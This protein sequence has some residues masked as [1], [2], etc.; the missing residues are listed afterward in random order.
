MG[1]RYRIRID[2]LDTTKVVSG[3]ATAVC[4]CF[5]S[6]CTS[7]PTP[8]KKKTT[9]SSTALSSEN[10]Q[11]SFETSVDTLAYMSC[12]DVGDSNYPNYFTL[13]VGAWD[14]GGV[15]LRQGLFGG[16]SDP[17]TILNLVSESPANKGSEPVLA[18]RKR[19]ELST[20]YAA[21]TSLTSDSDYAKM[22]SPLY[23]LS[24][25][26]A[27]TSAYLSSPGQYVNYVAKRTNDN[28]FMDT[29]GA[30]LEGSLRFMSSDRMAS[31]LRLK[32]MGDLL[33]T[34]TFSKSVQDAIGYQSSGD[35]AT[36][37][38][39]RSA[40]GVGLKPSFTQPIANRFGRYVGPGDF[41]RVLKGVD[42]FDLN[43][44][45]KLNSQWVC[46]TDLQFLIVRSE[47]YTILEKR[48]TPPNTPDTRVINCLPT[49]DP[50]VV[51]KDS[52]IAFLRRA[53]K[54][55][56][57]FITET[58]VSTSVG[59]S[60]LFCIIS[61]KPEG[62]YKPSTENVYYPVDVN[63]SNQLSYGSSATNPCD[64]NGD[65]DGSG[66]MRACPHFFSMCYRKR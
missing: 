42:E 50:T 65:F 33:V 43:T 31:D 10:L 58:T 13:K 18:V 41:N 27:L 2:L 28:P 39:A 35:P 21:T 61:K 46:P 20:M 24:V 60:Y 5:I 45:K 51:A 56:D 32:L 64:V 30:A 3:L 9:E 29:Y 59:P 48:A 37:G 54:P 49:A 44:G 14:T 25:T 66:P 63:A 47:D 12:S 40:Y 38:D 34:V 62:C 19:T 36:G 8:S 4:I 16:I 23:P 53:L 57:W 1:G 22:L 55:E 26:G 11:F 15:R 17:K 7:D 6:G 52:R